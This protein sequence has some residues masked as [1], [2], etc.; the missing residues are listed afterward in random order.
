MKFN[1]YTISDKGEFRK[2][3]QDCLYA[4][5]AQ[6]TDGSAFFGVVCDGMGG[7]SHGEVASSTVV[8]GFSDWFTQKFLTAGSAAERCA[9]MSEDWQSVVATANNT[10][11]ET[12][13][14]SGET[15]G[16][17]LSALLLFDG[18]FYAAQIGDSRIYIGNEQEK[19]FVPLTKDHSY[20]SDM[21][22]KGLMTPE[23]AR[24]S[25]EKNVL[26]RCIGVMREVSADL[27]S[28]EL[29]RGDY[30]VICSDGFCS[31][32]LPNEV[33]AAMRT[34]EGALAATQASLENAVARRRAGGERDNITAVFVSAD[35]E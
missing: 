28:G 11:R 18:R 12:A 32:T 10:L 7:L 19:L 5:T 26:T 27:F 9:G 24:L 21:V 14:S 29:H 15:M 22:D 3:N 33:L 4:N 23:E 16:T 6:T 2:S 35:W 17:T 31:G 1:Y 25:S 30:F 20:V 34:Q 13:A 8:R